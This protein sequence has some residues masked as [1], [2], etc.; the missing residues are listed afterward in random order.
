MTAR[1]T[2]DNHGSKLLGLEV[3]RF[4]S[5][6]SVLAWHYQHFSYV[7]GKP[8]GFV[9][10]QQPFYSL[11]SL[12]YDYGNYGVQVFWCISG[13]IFFWKYRD[14]I[15]S[16]VVGEK[17]FFTL[18]FSRLYPLHLATLMLVAVLQAIYFVQQG[19][20]F[21]YQNNDLVH[22]VF[23][24]FLASNWGVMKGPSF[25]GPVW[26][27]SVEVLIY[28]FFFLTLRYGS[29]SAWVNVAVL[30]V[31]FAAKLAG[32]TSP[33]VDCLAFFYVGGLSA[34]ALQYLEG[35]RWKERAISVAASI[36]VIAPIVTYVTGV[37]QHANFVVLFLF[38]YV[39]VLLYIAARNVPVRPAVQRI[40]EAAGNMTYSSYLIHFPIQLA[41]A[42]LFSRAKQAIPYYNPAFFAG[43][44]IATLV[45]SYYIYRFFEM[46]AQAFIRSRFTRQ[47]P[48]RISSPTARRS[49]SVQ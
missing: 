38:F 47:A 17:K 24:L 4:I 43:F 15:A 46:P 5:A 7:A 10:A 27:I 37:Y 48:A 30:A 28:G 13:F 19:Y 31:C 2:P 39:P 11:F 29:K 8:V 35:T 14:A 12:F 25:N 23:H 26:S 16:K 32:I 6:L 3:I 49:A 1:A 42:I 9:S 45:A 41:I 22:F 18:R 40:V 21:V 33:I 36:L 20:S 44:M 34:M